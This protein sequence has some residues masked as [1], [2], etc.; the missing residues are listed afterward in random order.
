M[1]TVEIYT[2]PLCGYCHA[3]KRLLA[4]KGAAFTEYDVSRDPEMRAQMMQRAKGG[5]TVPQIFIG[6]QH[7]GGSD[8]LHAL[9]HAGKLDA[10]LAG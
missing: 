7:V 3:A 6:D 4:K 2:S 8:D 9:D 5:R 10:L 1:K